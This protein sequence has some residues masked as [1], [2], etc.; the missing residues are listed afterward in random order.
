MSFRS[1][2]LDKTNVQ[3]VAALP[4]INEC[5]GAGGDICGE[6]QPDALYNTRVTWS[7][8]PLTLSML[9]RHM[10]EVTW[11]EIANGNVDRATASVP[12]MDA[13]DYVDLSAAWQFNDSFRMNI[14]VKNVFDEQPNF[15]GDYQEQ[16]NTFPSSYDIIGPRV[17]VSGSYA[18]E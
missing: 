18:F 9:W 3:P 8:G 4:E 10:D 7:S 16:G 6:P 5:A 2:F 17:F 1:T 13:Q 12:T 15:L 11:D 14:G